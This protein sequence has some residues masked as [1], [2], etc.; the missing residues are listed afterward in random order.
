MEVPVI[1]RFRI[2][3]VCSFGEFAAIPVERSI[4]AKKIV[5]GLLVDLFNGGFMLNVKLNFAFFRDGITLLCFLEW[6]VKVG[7]DIFNG[8]PL[9]FQYFGEVDVETP[10]VHL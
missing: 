7:N 3:A 2:I 10:P 9:F 6:K 1:L 8:L 4:V 5:P